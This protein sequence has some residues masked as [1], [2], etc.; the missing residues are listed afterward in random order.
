MWLFF[1]NKKSNVLLCWVFVALQASL[2][3]WHAGAALSLCCMGFCCRG[4]SLQ[5]T[6]SRVHRLRSQL[7]QHVGSVVGAPGSRA[8]DSVV[9]A[10]RLSFAP[11]HV[12][13]SQIKDQTHVSCTG[14]WILYHW[15]TKEAL[16]HLKNTSMSWWHGLVLKHCSLMQMESGIAVST[17]KR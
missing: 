10:Y 4:F 6:G 3:V 17:V 15:A 7:L 12:G 13:S 9:V 1:K 5:S 14:R 11:G 16:D 2:S 8:T